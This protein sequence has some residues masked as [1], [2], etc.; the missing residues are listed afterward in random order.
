MQDT[1]KDLTSEDFCILLSLAA[2]ALNSM[3]QSANTLQY[4]EA[5]D[6]EVESYTKLITSQNAQLQE[7]LEISKRAAIS[8]TQSAIECLESKHSKEILGL[9]TQID[10]LKSSLSISEAGIQQIKDQYANITTKSEEVYK[11]SLAEIAKQKDAQYAGEIS[12]IEAMNKERFSQNES[13]HR[14][15]IAT[16]QKVYNEQESRLKSQLE[17]TL[18]SSEIG[19]HGELEF[20]ELAELHTRWGPLTNTSKIPHSG[21]LAG[22]IKACS[23][24]FEIKRYSTDVPSKE[25]DKFL[26]DMD[27]HPEVP[28]GV[29]IS[30]KTNI[31]KKPGSFIQ[32]SWTARS[33]L[34]VYIS[35]FNEHYPP[36]IFSF[37]DICAEIA[38]SMFKI[39]NDRPQDSELNISLQSRLDQAKSIIECEVKRIVEFI[40]TINLQKKSLTETITKHHTENSLY[41]NQTKLSLKTMLDII[42][43]KSEEDEPETPEVISP[44]P[45]KSAKPKAIIS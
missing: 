8:E 45:R 2:N 37:I 21:D 33:Q 1:V 20:E 39:T 19:K 4:K 27:E 34:L 30:Q 13:Q 6:K 23:T 40:N 14:E 29:F 12:R 24:I 11:T 38:L 28:L 32:M 42:V 17:K 9:K 7:K 35:K 15:T 3:K 26:R 36:D 5:I 16:L 44:K 31:C 25:V 22:K 10:S 41:M 18:V 43:G